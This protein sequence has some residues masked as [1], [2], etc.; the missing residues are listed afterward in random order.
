M[1]RIKVLNQYTAN[2]IAAGE[3]VERPASVVKE[4]VENAIDAGS[5]SI[6]IETKGGGLESIRVTDNGSGIAAEDVETAFL[7]HATSKIGTA[8]DLSRIETLGFRG[9]AL[10]SIAA[11]AHVTLKTRASFD[12][13][14]TL[15]RISGGDKKELSEIGAA[16]GTSITVENLFY[17]VPARLKFMKSP[18]SEAAYISD[19]VSRMLMAHPEIAF[20][21]VQNGKTVFQ[22]AG[23]GNL[24]DAVYCVYGADVFPH[25]REVHYDDG[26]VR[27][28]GFIGT[29]QVSRNN[30]N[31]Q[32]FYINARYIKSQKLSYALQRAYDMRIMTGR[33]P[34]AV[35]NITISS[36][37]IDVNV[38][39]NKL[40]VR[41]KNEERV[42]RAA[43]IAARQALGDPVAAPSYF[44]PVKAQT[45][46]FGQTTEKVTIP[47]VKGIEAP[48]ITEYLPKEAASEVV[49]EE[50]NLLTASASALASKERGGISSSFMYT[51]P[52]RNPP[53]LKE[54]AR[55][56]VP[57]DSFPSSWHNKKSD[58]ASARKKD[59]GL[60]SMEVKTAERPSASNIEEKPLPIQK[61]DQT[62]FACS[63]YSI[64]GQVFQCYWLVQQ[65]DTLFFI[66]QHAAHERRL[67][68]RFAEKGVA[69]QSQMLLIPEIVKLTPM[70]YEIL[71]ENLAQ[72]REIGFEIEEFGVL[73]VSVRAVPHLIGQPETVPF[74]HEAIGLLDRKNRLSTVELKRAAL[75]Q[76][77]C[78]HAVKA[79]AS[80]AKEEIE[81][82]LSEYEA[83]GIP[84]TCPHGRPVMVK[85]S[86]LE[87]EK[88]F[89]RV[90]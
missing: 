31:A 33:F 18:R 8:E 29:E 49:S 63:A 47:P 82:L 43:T 27:L 2:Q 38:H 57:A 32:S 50:K 80:L 88:L 3:V 61:Q 87:F 25:L 39:P 51:L 20:K 60:P 73:T 69:A 40:D 4:L 15:L 83:E 46:L 42:M 66:D 44:T 75:I 78:K 85:M 81:A 74:L 16:E 56:V 52:D 24:Q 10:A 28:S 41:F 53:V 1:K 58:S 55:P 21:L 30:R 86:K 54:T 65:D 76:A 26:Y 77:S 70:E 13:T 19:Y 67:F 7:R 71:M 6:V 79:G 35:L 45:T 5:T 11:V 12:E 22:S 14:G 9:E 64:I 90:L 59:E 89:K 37:E 72:F 68:E 17:N 84:M 36:S 34:F 48:K 62:R 23:N